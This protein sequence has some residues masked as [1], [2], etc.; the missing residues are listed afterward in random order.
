MFMAVIR[1]MFS[2]VVRRSMTLWLK[3]RVAVMAPEN[4]PLLNIVLLVLAASAQG[5][6]LLKIMPVVSGD[7]NVRCK[8]L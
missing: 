3:H 8:K 1:F 4:Q 5:R 6:R 7:S 2:D